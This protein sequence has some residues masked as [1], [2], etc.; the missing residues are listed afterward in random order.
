M[1]FGPMYASQNV[2]RVIKSRWMK[3]VGHVEGMEEM[4]NAYIFVGKT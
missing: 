1:M 2:I 3:L 4:R